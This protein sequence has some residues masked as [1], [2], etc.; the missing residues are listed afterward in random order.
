MM[1]A[2]SDII[3]KLNKIERRLA[4]HDEKILLIFSYIRQ[5]ETTKHKDLKEKEREP[6]G[7]KQKNQ[8]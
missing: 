3:E 6:I 4:D 7:F 8:S 2:N 5:L 1:V